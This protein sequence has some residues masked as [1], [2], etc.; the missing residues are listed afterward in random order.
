MTDDTNSKPTG[1]LAGKQAYHHGNLHAALLEAGELLLKE[2]GIAGISLRAV[3]KAA[4]VSHAAPYRHFRDKEH[5]LASVAERGFESLIET[6]Q[7]AAG[8]QD[9]PAHR[10]REA[11]VAYVSFAMQN[12]EMHHLMFGGL[13]DN[14]ETA[15]VLQDS[16][17]RAFGTLRN[18]VDA[19][20]KADIYRNSSAREITL[21]AWSLMHGFAMLMSTGQLQSGGSIAQI[22]AMAR[23]QAE[24]LLQG[25]RKAGDGQ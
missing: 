12:S 22:E 3:A 6:M 8:E 1:A 19:G 23:S 11:A 17:L 25:L 2:Q 13:L 14:G 15:L 5:L 9:D 4:G 24:L 18:I 16:R 7:A 10:L 20:V 21:T